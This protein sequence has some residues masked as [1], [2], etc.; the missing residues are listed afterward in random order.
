MSSLLQ[1]FSRQQQLMVRQEKEV[2][3]K[4]EG[5]GKTAVDKPLLLPPYR[6]ESIFIC[7]HLRAISPLAQRT[8]IFKWKFHPNAL[9]VKYF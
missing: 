8:P 9:A 3:K 7:F 5:F 6:D 2:T 1:L 4:R